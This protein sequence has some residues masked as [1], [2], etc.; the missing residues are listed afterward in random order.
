MDVKTARKIVQA[1]DDLGLELNIREE[2][3]GRGMFGKKT[4]GVVFDS[5][6]DLLQS[7][8][9]AAAETAIEDFEEH[10]GD[11]SMQDFMEGLEIKGQDNMGMSSIVY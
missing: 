11:E 3:S 7:V 6:N 9:H 4:A 5:L 8:A 2:Y 1:G 10:D